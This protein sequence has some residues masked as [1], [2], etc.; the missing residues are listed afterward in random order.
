MGPKSPA[1]CLTCKAVT[2]LRVDFRL[3]HRRAGGEAVLG[4]VVA[5]VRSLSEEGGSMGS[6]SGVSVGLAELI[7]PVGEVVS[8]ATIKWK[9]IAVARR[10]ESETS[11]RATIEADVRAAA[12]AEAELGAGRGRKSFVYVTVGTGISA[13]LVI[14]GEP[15]T[16]HRG[17]AGRL[18]APQC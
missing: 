1:D 9:D 2:F 17:L 12:R 10:I 8:D 6:P 5:M 14:D 3:R 11:L 18:R 7:S 13:C 4:N 15:Y 16:G